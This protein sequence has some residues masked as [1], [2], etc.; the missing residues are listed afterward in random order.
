[1]SNRKMRTPWAWAVLV[2]AL[3]LLIPVRA[4]AI[5]AGPDSPEESVRGAYAELGGL[6]WA[7]RSPARDEEIAQLLARDVDFDELTRRAFGEP[8]PRPGCTDHWAELTLEQRT[9]VEPLFAAV[10]TR[11]WTHEL[12]KASGYDIDVQPAV[13]HSH[14]TRVRVLVRPK[15]DPGSVPVVVDTFILPN[16]VPY[17]LVDV[18]VDGSRLAR[19]YYKQFDRTLTSPG[20]GYTYLVSRL[21]KKVDKPT[22]ERETDAGAQTTANDEVDA[23]PPLDAQTPAPA[24]KPPPRAFPWLPVALGGVAAVVLGIWIGRLRRPHLPDPPSRKT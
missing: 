11:Q 7:P 23:A 5:D 13:T 10:V 3:G 20:E 22:T 15:G 17:R 16:H 6:L 24:A 14:D 21:H 19:S 1:M 18:D 4:E 8:C 9:E 2:L 12:G